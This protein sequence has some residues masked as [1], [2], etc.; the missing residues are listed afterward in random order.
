[1][2]TTGGFSSVKSDTRLVAHDYHVV[3]RGF[4][5]KHTAGSKMHLKGVKHKQDLKEHIRAKL[6][7]DQPME[8]IKDIALWMPGYEEWVGL[9]RELD[10]LRA[11]PLAPVPDC[12]HLLQL[13]GADPG[14]DMAPP[15]GGPPPLELEPEPDPPPPPFGD[16]PPKFQTPASAPPPSIRSAAAA[17]GMMQGGFAPQ[18]P[19]MMMSSPSYDGGGG[20]G[21]AFNGRPESPDSPDSAY[22]SNGSPRAPQMLSDQPL[23]KALRQAI[24]T[25]PTMPDQVRAAR[26]LYFAFFAFRN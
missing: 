17:A 13:Y 10:E 8:P 20:Y 14:G 4:G 3:V 1:M 15:D 23:V 19:T 12:G 6:M 22:D 25:I 24:R 2:M 7:K 18:T 21:S 11:A 16:A 9:S 5:V 26:P